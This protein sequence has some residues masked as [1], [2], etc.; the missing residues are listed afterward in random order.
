MRA[1]AGQATRSFN[2]GKLGIHST[3]LAVCMIKPQS[4][5][6]R[7]EAKPRAENG[8]KKNSKIT[9]GKITNKT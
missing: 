7:T 8:F 5:K 9:E 1:G 6:H 4:I 3:L 2:I